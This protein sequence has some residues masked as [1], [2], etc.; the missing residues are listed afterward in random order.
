MISLVIPSYNNLRHLKNA[1]ASIKKHAPKIEVILL[2][3]GSTDGTWEWIWQLAESHQHRE[4]KAYKSNERV[5]HTILYD[6]G[7][8]MATNDIV[9]I[10]H[11]DMIVGPKYVENMLKHLKP[12]T[13]VCGT[14]IEPPLHPEGKEKIIANFGMDFD[15]LNIPAFESFCVEKQKEFKDR[16]TLGMFAPWILYKKDFVAM[17]GHDA[18]F[19][20][21]PYEDSDIFQRWLLA[22]YELVQSR[23]AFVYHLTCRGHRWTE[24][25]QKDDDYYKVASRN[26]ARNYLRKW[27]TWIKNDEYQHPIVPKVYDV[28]FKVKNADIN[29]IQVLEPWCK[30][31]FVDCEWAQVKEYILREQNSCAVDLEAKIKPIDFEIPNNYV[32]EFDAK[33]INEDRF[34]T[35]FSMLD[36]L[37]YQIEEPG[38]YEVDVFKVSVKKL[39]PMDITP[40]FLLRK[41]VF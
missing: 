39:G 33:S 15:D 26:A 36:Q 2:D 16:T 27:G 12:K 11:A 30:A 13:V 14:R 4:V 21:F 8:E 7:I 5:G 18:A 29:L 1:Y 3:D 9:G 24:K 20:P 25:V 35:Y 34:T 40:L 38:E 31:M 22:G 6:K 19:A 32:M 10:M 17:G 41:N 23:D 37:L 28:A